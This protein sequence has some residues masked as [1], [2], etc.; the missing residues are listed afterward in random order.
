MRLELR[1]PVAGVVV[2]INKGPGVEVIVDDVVLVVES[3][4]MEI[5]VIAECEGVIAEI[6]VAPA[7]AVSEGQVLAVVTRR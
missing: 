4:K 6:C 7:E 1:S 5:P 2:A 3:M